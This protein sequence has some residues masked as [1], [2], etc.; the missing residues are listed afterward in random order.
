MMRREI[1]GT[2]TRDDDHRRIDSW[3]TFSINAAQAAIRQLD[4]AQL[5]AHIGQQLD[6][7]DLLAPGGKSK[8]RFTGISRATAKNVAPS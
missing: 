2:V 5:A 7:D 3:S 6:R 8:S 4:D 1:C